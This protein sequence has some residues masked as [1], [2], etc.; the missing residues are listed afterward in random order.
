MKSKIRILIPTEK[1]NLDE[2]LSVKVAGKKWNVKIDELRITLLSR[3]EYEVPGEKWTDTDIEVDTNIH[4]TT[5]RIV[6]HVRNAM[7]LAYG[8]SMQW[9]YEAMYGNTKADD[10]LELFPSIHQKGTSITFNKKTLAVRREMFQDIGS[11]NS[12]PVTLMLNYWR[13]AHELDD[14]GFDSEAYLNYYKVLECL[15]GMDENK[16]KKMEFL[17]KFAPIKLISGTKQRKPMTKIRR[18]LG[19][20][21]TDGQIEV[22]IIKASKILATSKFTFISTDFVI[23]LI[24]LINVRDEFNV[25]HNLMVYIPK[26][27]Y[28]GIGQHS[29]SFS[30]VIRYISSIAALS[31]LTI[32]NYAFPK[33]YAYDW[34]EREWSIKK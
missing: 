21:P 7:Y 31:K 1:T 12:K 18:H 16:A 25:A 9:G 13:R 11:I 23:H 5:N 30:Y 6:G 19:K 4:K 24:D 32:L 10:S 28:Y 8:V 15:E 20:R 3:D 2:T 29:D 17:N 34:K 33:K 27:S 22:Q 14:L 26:D